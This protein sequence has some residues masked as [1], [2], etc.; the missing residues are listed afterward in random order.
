MLKAE[1]A[2]AISNQANQMTTSSLFRLPG[3]TLFLLPPYLVAMEEESQRIFVFSRDWRNFMNTSK[4]HFREWKHQ[5]QL[6]NLTVKYSMHFFKTAAFRYLVLE[7]VNIPSLQLSINLQFNRNSQNWVDL[8][9]LPELKRIEIDGSP[10]T[11]V[12]T[13]PEI[14]Y[15]EILFTGRNLRTINKPFQ[16]VRKLSIISR[17]S[18]V[19]DLSLFLNL[20]VL[21]LYG[22]TVKNC[23]AMPHLKKASFESCEG[24]DG[25]LSWLETVKYLSF[26]HISEI[27]DV[28]PLK[29]SSTLK[30]KSCRNIYDVSS[31]G[32][33]RELTFEDCRGIS[34]VSQLGSVR[35]LY[36]DWCVGI[37]N[38]SA[39]NSVRKLS[40]HSFEGRD[41]SSL[42]NVMILDLRIPVMLQI[43]VI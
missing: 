2:A 7:T 41:I 34:D 10:V 15:N 12:F 16:N 27:E 37:E 25:N 8:S 9:I 24:F 28:T 35:A 4:E 42:L 17:S 1:P 43:L 13:N 36:I 33:V 21:K 20:E 14:C 22:M 32:N 29:E 39:L 19:I 38:I 31:L 18:A 5:S 23:R 6:I 26:D 3:D 30:F 11:S 40:L